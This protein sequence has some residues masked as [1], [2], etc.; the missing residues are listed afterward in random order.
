MRRTSAVSRI[1]GFRAF[2]CHGSWLQ[3]G[4]EDDWEPR[5]LVHRP[6][7]CTAIRKHAAGRIKRV[8]TWD[9]DC[10]ERGKSLQVVVP[11]PASIFQ[12]ALRV[13]EGS[14]WLLRCGNKEDKPVSSAILQAVAAM[15]GAKRVPGAEQAWLWTLEDAVGQTVVP[16]GTGAL[17]LLVLDRKMPE[18]P[19]MD[20][21]EQLECLLASLWSRHHALLRRLNRPATL[22]L[23]T[24]GR[25]TR[26][27]LHTLLLLHR[28][29]WEDGVDEAWEEISAHPRTEIDVEYPEMPVERARRPVLHGSKGPW[30]LS[31]GWYPESDGGRVR[32]RQPNRS[33]DVPA[34]RLAVRLALIVETLA[35]RVLRTLASSNM[36]SATSWATSARRLRS[37]A[38]RFRSAP[39]L[40]DVMPYSPLAVDSPSV[41]LDRSCRPLLQAW[42]VLH[43]GLAVDSSVESLLWDP[44]KEAYD[45][46]E[47]WCWFALCEA[48]QEA[49][50]V[51]GTTVATVVKPIE[52]F[53]GELRLRHG[54]RHDTRVGQKLIR[55]HYNAPARSGSPYKSYSRNF[56]PD[57]ALE[58]S[59][60]QQGTSGFI[61]FDAKYRVLNVEEMAEEGMENAR[62]ERRG[63]AKTDDLKVMHAYRE[64][65]RGN[66]DSVPGWVLTLF[67]GTEIQLWPD[68]GG[69]S[70][71]SLEVL[72]DVAKGGVGAI[73]AY[74]A[75]GSGIGGAVKKAV[76][77]ILTRFGI[78]T[79]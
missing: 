4:P 2:D 58:F 61:L 39:S 67:P 51:P 11:A 14:R 78:V 5:N 7:L 20:R 10:D 55:L 6:E 70:C 1:A 64:A 23:N 65:L 57:F 33:V 15:P 9:E 24:T 38:L 21:A 40:Q 60:G 62:A 36:A 73:P 26:A 28:L 43:K 53:S 49:T 76:A 13:D 25:M 31:E 74:P 59:D 37:R 77:S 17:P 66:H 35:D 72:C 45:L 79:S 3:F 63:Y 42:H 32:V 54:L 34:N 41:Q 44:L 12:A 56:R 19:G 30:T 47:Y 75:S 22:R 71:D 50:G 69:G 48:V 16:V 52:T 27:P 68:C 18:T 29:V 46:Y 8:K